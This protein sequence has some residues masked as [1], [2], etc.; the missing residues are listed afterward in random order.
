M[1]HGRSP[2]GLIGEY[3]PCA[4]CDW[5]RLEGANQPGRRPPRLS[6]KNAVPRKEEAKTAFTKA[7]GEA[8]TIIR[9][10]LLPPL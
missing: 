6:L 8:I 7:G 3:G 1:L 5:G 2:S 10:E 9:E 4:E